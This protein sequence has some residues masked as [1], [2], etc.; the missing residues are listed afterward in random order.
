MANPAFNEKTLNRLSAAGELA[1]T[2]T[3][4]THGTV[5]KLGFLVILTVLSSAF[6]WTNAEASYAPFLAG[7]AI[8]ANLVLAF[9]IIFNKSKAPVLAPVYA[10]V[11]GLS[12]GFISYFVDKGAPGIAMHAFVAT[13]GILFLMLALYS[14]GVL[15]ATPKFVKIVVGASFGILMIYV[16]DLVLAFFGMNVPMIHQSGPYGIIFSA[17]VVVVASMNLIIDFAMIETAVEAQAPKY[18]EWYGGFAIL[19]TLIWLYLE[20]LRLLGKTRK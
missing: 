12:L 17:F 14:A 11:E 9:V 7:G 1:G 5:N 15:Q 6:A 10:L 16:L 3:M 2:E 19:L 4:T 18:M 13:F 20:I 8:L